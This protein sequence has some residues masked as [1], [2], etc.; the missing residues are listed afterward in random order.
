MIDIYADSYWKIIYSQHYKNW[1]GVDHTATI[2]HSSS[3]QSSQPT[4][5]NYAHQSIIQAFGRGGRGT[6]LTSVQRSA[7]YNRT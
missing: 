1:N 3:Q 5:N 2:N 6:V 4:T 7:N